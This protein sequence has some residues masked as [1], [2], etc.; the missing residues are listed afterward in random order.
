MWAIKIT[1]K[2]PFGWNKLVYLPSFFGQ[3]ICNVTR[4]RSGPLAV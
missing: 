2:G 1:G 3:F 4:A